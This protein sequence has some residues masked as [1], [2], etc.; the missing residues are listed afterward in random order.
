[1]GI[2]SNLLPERARLESG[3][4]F[5][6]DAALG[7]G[8]LSIGA[9]Q[10]QLTRN[11]NFLDNWYFVD[12]INQ[13]GL[14]Q[15]TKNG[16]TI[17]RWLLTHTGFGS[18]E[19][20]AN[21]LLLINTSYKTYITQKLENSLNLWEKRLTLSVIVNGVLISKVIAMP[22][23]LTSTDPTTIAVGSKSFDGK[24]F[25]ASFL[26]K[27]SCLQVELSTEHATSFLLSACK[28]ELG[29]QQ[30]IAY[31]DADGNWVLNDPPPNK[32]LEL[33]KCQRYYQL[34]SSESARPASLADYRPPM[35]ANPA[36][37][38][39]VIDGTTY[40]TADANL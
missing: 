20:N 22:E 11:W 9:A 17:D 33:L 14:N 32:A 7:T 30:T 13:R 37:G 39:I 3:D 15:Y 24:I 1:M 35:R 25:R 19:L 36:L 8:R 23:Q 31:Q 16:Y 5:L 38:T 34:F 2:K 28:L 40:Y 27:D 4:S 29:D 26:W 18:V 21:G 6:V 10:N 12:P